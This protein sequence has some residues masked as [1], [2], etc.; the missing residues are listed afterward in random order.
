MSV[1]IN[2]GDRR[3]GKRAKKSLFAAAAAALLQNA[4]HTPFLPSPHLHCFLR[5]VLVVAMPPFG[6]V[7][8]VL[9]SPYWASAHPRGCLS[10]GAGGAA[11]FVPRALFVVVCEQCY[12]EL[13]RVPPLLVLPPACIVDMPFPDLVQ[14]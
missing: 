12:P 11:E 14:M 3:G 7:P 13:C 10:R 2:C 5:P 6:V 1:L 4:F 8:V 9:C